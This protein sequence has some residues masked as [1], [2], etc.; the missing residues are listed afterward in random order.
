[1]LRLLPNTSYPSYPPV[2]TIA[3]ASTLA[4]PAPKTP[5]P[6]SCGLTKGACLYKT[7]K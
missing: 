3:A 4:I 6:L 7:I 2:S 1:M 5:G